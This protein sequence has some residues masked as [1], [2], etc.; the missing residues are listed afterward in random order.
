MDVGVK[1]PNAV[2]KVSQGQGEIDGNGRF[3]DT[4]FAA[5]DGQDASDTRQPLWLR[6][7]KQMTLPRIRGR[8]DHRVLSF[9]WSGLAFRARLALPELVS[10][11]AI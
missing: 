3:A 10:G 6:F 2:A 9:A 11:S 7:A 8:T 4:P 1:Q 5:G